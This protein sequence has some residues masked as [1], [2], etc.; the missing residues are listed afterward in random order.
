MSYSAFADYYDRLMSDC[1]YKARADYLFGLFSRYSHPPKLLLDL[2]CGTGSLSLEM[3]KLGCDVIAVDLSP[4]MLSIANEKA[5]SDGKELLCLCQSADQL[6]LYGT[7]DG[8]VCTLDSINHIIDEEQL[9]ETFKKVSL[10]LEQG[11]LFIFDVNTVYKHEQILADETYVMDDGDVYCVWQ[12]SYDPPF[13]DIILDFFEK[14][15]GVYIRSGEEFSERAYT[16]D[17]LLGFAEDAG[18]E[19][20]AVFEDMTYDPVT[21]R[22]ERAV[23]VLRKK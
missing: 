12:N 10:F 23:Y 18:L 15:D 9:R 19:Q 13:T 5:R 1:D 6:D 21:D 14:K 22:C 17:E 11:C 8:V 4:E 16:H 7:V 2:C 20:V 3:I